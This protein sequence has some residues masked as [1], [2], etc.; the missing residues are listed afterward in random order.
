MSGLSIQIHI[1]SG[2]LLHYDGQ[3]ARGWESCRAKNHPCF[4]HIVIRFDCG[5]RLYER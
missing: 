2:V 5:W 4:G 3:F 1:N